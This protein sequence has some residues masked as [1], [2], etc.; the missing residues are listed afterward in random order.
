[1]NRFAPIFRILLVGSLILSLGTVGFC[2]RPMMA[3][4]GHACARAVDSQKGRTCC[5]PGCDGRCDGTCCQQQGSKPTAPSQPSRPGNEKD[6]L[7]VLA[8]QIG[9][10]AV[11]NNGGTAAYRGTSSLDG[12][13][14]VVSLQSQ[15]VRIQT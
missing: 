4:P 15:H 7:V 13:Q 1:M 14:A 3:A 6:N 9:S 8:V 12:A 5:C 11:G 10:L 2:S